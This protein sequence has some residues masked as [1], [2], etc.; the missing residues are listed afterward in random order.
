MKLR[1]KLG[2][3]TSPGSITHTFGPRA[4]ITETRPALPEVPCSAPPEARPEAPSEVPADALVGEIAER[5]GRIANLRAQLEAIRV[6]HAPARAAP[7]P[8]RAPRADWL[9]DEAY[10]VSPA[11][12]DA[13]L[14]GEI[15]DT[16]HGPLCRVL[17]AHPED[18]RHGSA[19]V[20]AACDVAGC[21]VA[22][23]SLDPGLTAL[24]F[25]RALYI[26]TETTG[27]SGGSGTLPFLIGMA[28]FEGRCLHVEQ[29]LLP[30]PGCETPLLARLRERLAGASVIVSYNGKSF[31]WPLLRTRFVMNRMSTPALPAHLDLLH[32]ARRVY[33]SRLGSVRLVNLEQE[34]LGFERVDDISGEF[35]PQTYLAF[36]RGAASGSTLLPIV[37]HN[38]SDLVA[39]PALLGEIVRRFGAHAREDARDQLGFARVAARAAQAERAIAIAHGAAE[40]DVRGELAGSALYLVGELRLRRGELE[41]A[42]EAFEGALSQSTSRL[43]GARVHLA[44]AKLHEHK[45]KR[46]DSALA[47]ASHTAPVEGDEACA[48]RVARLAQRLARKQPGTANA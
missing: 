40:A 15:L 2:R 22:L 11:L 31:D 39:L 18:H 5:R 46:Y 3:L 14:P 6:A 23:L 25:S 27:L 12:V 37:A 7:A 19:D 35:I 44:L 24:D 4:P 10:P 36:L 9:D 42:I 1:E 28:W 43:D 29:L 41:A 34:L 33:K 20:V 21:E 48:R 38:R 13:T 8:V 26:D 16:V 30:K 47:H 32:C 45:T 17:T